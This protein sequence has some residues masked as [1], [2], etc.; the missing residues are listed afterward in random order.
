MQGQHI[1]QDLKGVILD[2]E[3]APRFL[4]A[5]ACHGD[6]ET[7][8]RYQSL[9]RLPAYRAR[10]NEEYEHYPKALHPDHVAAAFKQAIEKQLRVVKPD[11]CHPAAISVVSFLPPENQPS[12]SVTIGKASFDDVNLPN[13]L[14]IRV[15]VDID[16]A[17]DPHIAI[18]SVSLFRPEGVPT[19]TFLN[20]Q[21]YMQLIPLNQT[22][23]QIDKQFKD[24]VWHAEVKFT[25]GGKLTPPQY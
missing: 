11:Q 3:F 25:A 5:Q 2:L 24:F 13:T 8:F 7:C 4:E 9:A 19:S 6:D 17:L 20:T 12:A 1:F 16:Y 21:P 14:T 22:E 10:L 23:D 15:R 18:L